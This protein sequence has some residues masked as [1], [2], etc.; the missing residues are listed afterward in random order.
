MTGKHGRVA[1]GRRATAGDELD[2][3][4]QGRCTMTQNISSQDLRRGDVLLSLGVGRTSTA[5]RA[6][7]GGDYSHA[8]LWSGDGVIEATTPCVQEH[9]LESSLGKHPREYVDAFRYLSMPVGSAELVVTA[10]RQSIDVAYSYG[11]LFLCASLMAVAS[12]LPRRG[13]LPLLKEVCEM[14]HVM[15]RDGARPGEHMTCTKLVVRSYAAAGLALHIRP[16][17]P[18]RVDL[19]S[20][21]GAAEEL[22]RDRISKDLALAADERDEWLALQ[23]ELRAQCA[24]LDPPDAA[25]RGDVPKGPLRGW[26]GRTPVQAV[27]EWRS[28]LVTPYN[29]QQSPDLAP[30]G[31]L[32]AASGARP[33]PGTPAR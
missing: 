32:Y 27:G 15:Q 24:A 9:G 26:D 21:Y 3:A 8:A 29:L 20:L 4:C 33:Q 11:D 13:Q 19:R 30:I 7:A 14:F 23:A 16:T 1:R 12:Q 31:R 5:I 28:Q 10:A 22:A 18:D 25:S 6:L 17:P 2:N